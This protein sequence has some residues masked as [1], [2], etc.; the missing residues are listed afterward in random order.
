[1]FDLMRGVRR[2]LGWVGLV[3]I[4]GSLSF[5]VF[6][7]QEGIC[8]D[9]VK[10]DQTERE[11]QNMNKLT[12]EAQLNRPECKN[13]PEILRPDCDS[14][15]SK[16]QIS[17]LACF[18]IT[19]GGLVTAGLAAGKILDKGTF[20]RA[21]SKRPIEVSSSV[22]FRAFPWIVGAV[23]GGGLLYLGL[24][25]DNYVRKVLTEA[26]Q[27]GLNPKDSE[28]IRKVARQEFALHYG[29]KIYD[30]LY[31]NRHCYNTV[32]QHVRVCG[33]LTALAGG[34]VVAGGVSMG[35]VSTA[36]TG[37]A[38]GFALGSVTGMIAGAAVGIP[39]YVL[40]KE[41]EKIREDVS[42]KLQSVEDNDP[43]S[44]TESLDQFLK[45]TSQ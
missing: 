34:S 5:S 20:I 45:E 7:E 15:E 27:R 41:Y 33:L 3:F 40:S 39:P 25:Y 42:K 22:I 31:G 6:G 2:C 44:A 10:G 1:M 17:E 43:P 28:S 29:K 32:V 16:R 19:L 38:G 13:V 30:L 35:L 4:A 11:I 12:C 24:Q 14:T 9:C 37:G 21:L 36:I 18:S 26:R 23:A 8:V